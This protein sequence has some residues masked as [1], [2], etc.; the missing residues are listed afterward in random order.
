MAQRLKHRW[1]GLGARIVAAPVFVLAQMAAVAHA[2]ADHDADASTT[3]YII[4]CVIHSDDDATEEPTAGI[5]VGPPKHERYA[6]TP[7][8]QIGAVKLDSYSVVRGPPQ[9]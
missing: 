4:C 5:L 1:K 3:H 9:N 7:A 6:S 8:S 2:E